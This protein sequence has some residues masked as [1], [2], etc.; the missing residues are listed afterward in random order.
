MGAACLSSPKLALFSFH[1]C[2]KEKQTKN[3]IFGRFEHYVH[4]QD[5]IKGCRVNG[6]Y[7]DFASMEFVTTSSTS[8]VKK[9]E[10]KGRVNGVRR[11]GAYCS[12]VGF[13]H[14]QRQHG[15]S[16]IKFY[17]FPKDER[18]CLWAQAF[19]RKNPDESSGMPSS[20]TLC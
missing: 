14:N 13:S 17:F 8:G 10:L 2:R 4:Y 12:A 9:K 6:D 1:F 5:D 20:C 3:V 7:I 15:L 11:G 16:G 19:K 18:K